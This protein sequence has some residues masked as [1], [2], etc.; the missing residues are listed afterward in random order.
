MYLNLNEKIFSFFHRFIERKYHL[1]KLSKILKST[2]D[3]KNPIIF[4]VGG[5][6]GESIDFFSN[7]FENPKIYSFEPETK[8]YQKLVKIRLMFR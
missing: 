5:N 6:E 1:K 7:L 8:S 4:D 2:I 3:F